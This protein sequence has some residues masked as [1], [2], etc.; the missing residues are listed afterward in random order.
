MVEENGYDD[1]DGKKI[2][3]TNHKIPTNQVLEDLDRGTYQTNT[4]QYQIVS[5]L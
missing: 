5:L 2:F 4:K 1:G 3:L